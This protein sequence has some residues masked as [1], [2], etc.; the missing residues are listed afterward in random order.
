MKFKHLFFTITFFLHLLSISFAQEPILLEH[1]GGVRTVEFSPINAS[2]LASAGESNIIKLWN[3]QND[4]VQTLRGHTGIVNSIAFSPNGELL[5]SGGEDRTIKLWNVHNQQKIATFQHSNARIKSLAF[6]PDGRILATGGDWHV[7][8]WNVRDWTEIAT[9]RHEAWARALVFSPDGQFLAAGKGHEGPGIVTVWN[10]QT[11]QVIAT[12]E[13]DSNRVRTLAFSPDNRILASSG[14]DRKLKLWSVSNWELLNTIPHAGEYGITF[15]PDGKTLA[16]TNNGYVNLWWVENG[17]NVARIPGPTGWMHPVNFSHDGRYL[18]IGAEDGIVRIWPI[19]I[20]FEDNNNGGIQILHIDTYLQQLPKANSANGDNIPEPVPPPD[21]VRAFFDLDPFYQQWINVEGFP[22]VAS[23]NVNPY[24]LKEAAWLIIK[25]I[26]HRS[27]LLYALVQ[28]KVRFAVIGHTEMTTQIP[29]YS[30]RRPAFYWDRRVRG[31]GGSAHSAV[32]CTEEN[33]LDYPGDTA[34][35]GFQLIHE[36]AHAIH[37]MGL[38]TVDPEFDAR[39][40]ITYDAAMKKGLW[41]GTYAASDRSEY[42]AEGTHAWIDPKGGSSF[43]RVHGG[44]TRAELKTYDPDLATLLTE[45]YGDSEWRYTPIVTRPQLPHL[46]GFNP[47]DSPTFEWPEELEETYAQ[48]RDPYIDSGDE[49]VNLNLYKPSQLSHLNKPRISGTSTHVLFVNLTDID[50]LVYRVHP[51]GTETFIKRIY[52]KRGLRH[53]E[54]FGSRVGDAYLVKDQDGRNLAVFRAE[55]QTGRALIDT[56]SNKTNQ[57]A[58]DNVVTTKTSLDKITGPWLWMIAPTAV[59]QG[60]AKSINMDSL[61]EASNGAVTESDVATNGAVEGDSVGNLVW[62]LGEISPTG[63][64]NVTDLINEIGLGKGDVDDY[65]SYALI[66]LE[67]A[68]AQ[69]DVTMA[70]GSDDVIKVWLNGEVVHNTPIN[71]EAEDFQDT[72]KVNLVAGDNL[73][74]VKVSNRSKHWSMFVGIDADVNAVYKRSSDAVETINVADINADGTVN[75]IDLLLLIVALGEDTPSNPRTDVNGD[76]A[77]NMEDLLLVVENLDDP[78][79]AAPPIKDIAIG[80]DPLMLSGQL[81]ILRTESDGSLKYQ[82]AITFLQNLLAA[83]RPEETLL[84]ANYPNPFNPETWIP[85]QL[86]K[87]AEVT[88]HIYAVNGALI[89]TLTLGHQPAGMY[90]SKS[91]AAYWNGRNEQGERVASG[92]YLYTLSAGDFTAT[93]KMF[94]QK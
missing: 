63:G 28:N 64:N 73:L 88:L 94:I 32:S 69:S 10:V 90:H 33:L 82:Q 41:R 59:G 83:I 29:E 21:V 27:D 45:I 50:V 37:H 89:R 74:L 54:I 11:R 48:L 65:S 1:D 17:V 81:N 68:T 31:L 62:T 53:A 77:V 46:Q 14:R 26:G 22:V 70:A 36:F 20:S 52:A 47:Q 7:K 18:A 43:K 91:L 19:N 13:G 16:G 87:P 35:N 2:L 56:P 93:R 30:D 42:W 3:L 12:L 51:D 72:F 85:Y 4:T 15:S 84:L 92:V 55:E 79:A 49:W 38:N 86:S 57:T 44:N 5:A 23:A 78:V 75:L 58:Q 71:R 61:S 66:T 8:L 76:G 24:A 39:L 67:S 34:P 40:K 9:L 80:L 25:M 60:G 6:S